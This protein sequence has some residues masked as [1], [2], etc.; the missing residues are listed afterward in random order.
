MALDRI[1]VAR[2]TGIDKH[3]DIIPVLRNKFFKEKDTK[4]LDYLIDIIFFKLCLQALRMGYYCISG[5]GSQSSEMLIHKEVA[6]F[7]FEQCDKEIKEYHEF[8][9]DDATDEEILTEYLF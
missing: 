8:N 6:Q 4:A 5:A 2:M 9:D 7:I 1:Y 3:N